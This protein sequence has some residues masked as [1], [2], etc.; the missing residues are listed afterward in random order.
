MKRL[1]YR[2]SHLNDVIFLYVWVELRPYVI[3]LYLECRRLPFL[4]QNKFDWAYDLVNT[5]DFGV[6]KFSPISDFG[7]FHEDQNWRFFIF[8]SSAI[9]II[10]FA[11]FVN[12][13]KCPRREIRENYYLVN[14]TRSTVYKMDNQ[15]SVTKLT[16][17]IPSTLS[18]HKQTDYYYLQ[19]L[20]YLEYDAL[21]KTVGYFTQLQTSRHSTPTAP[22]LMGMPR[23]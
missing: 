15:C 23:W 22:K 4:N 19:W 6:F 17:H 3:N 2:D 5:V 8:F 20:F 10:I 11:R 14:I 16:I 21:P 1:C 12:S 7:T 13:R 9:M 18:R